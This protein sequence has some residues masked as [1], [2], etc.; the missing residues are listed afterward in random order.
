MI[1]FSHYT[2]NKKNYSR[3]KHDLGSVWSNLFSNLCKIAY[4]NK[5]I[6][7]YY[8][9]FVKVLYDKITYKNTVLVSRNL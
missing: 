1:Q 2:D 4:A 5:Y 3:G 7:M 9:K 8:Y 6:C